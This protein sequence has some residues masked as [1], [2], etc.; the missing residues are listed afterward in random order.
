M[1]SL[2]LVEAAAH[3]VGNPFALDAPS[4]ERARARLAVAPSLV[5]AFARDASQ[6]EQRVLLLA[7]AYIERTSKKR[8]RQVLDDP[9]WDPILRRAG[10]RRTAIER[11]VSAAARCVESL[12]SVRGSSAAMSA[13]R[14]DTWSAC[15]GQSLLRALDLERVIRDH[16]ILIV[17]ETG[18]GKEAIAR[19]VVAGT[20]GDAAGGP[21]PSATVNAAAVPDT[22]I[23]S[24]LFGHV[25]GAFTG[26]T[27]TRRGRIRAASGGCFFLDEVGDLPAFTQVKLLRVIEN[28]EVTPLGADQTVTIDVRFVAATHKPL[29]AMIDDG[30]FRRDLYERLAGMV[31]VMPPLRERP[32]DILHIGMSFV[33]GSGGDALSSR[34]REA[35][36]NWLAS[37]A[38]RRYPWPG[39]V[40]ELQNALRSLLLGIPPDLGTLG[41]PA[42][43]PELPE[44]IARF[45]APL[46]QVAGW[47]VRA[48]I[49]SAKGNH[50]EAARRLAVDRA[51]VKRYAERSTR[52]SGSPM[53]SPAA[54]A[55]APKRRAR[56]RT[57]SRRPPRATRP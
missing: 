57:D 27:E 1:P 32:E 8:L 2:A 19:A 52:R 55:N 45:E 31:I 7:R 21:A 20:P 46:R 44:R 39:N 33:D 5:A 23:E 56:G 6:D 48:V 41:T 18:T 47:Y 9:S 35:I 43:S 3:I 49:E 53:G 26:A 37:S 14:R 4:L 22:L 38:A 16:D 36:G 24:E 25:K 10:L 40:R 34:D 29:D 28:D 54:P 15:F 30:S 13:V 17:G 11:V 42:S 12:A 50:S 51:T